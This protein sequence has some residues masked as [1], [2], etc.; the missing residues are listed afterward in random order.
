[1]V[2]GP[3]WRTAAHPVAAR[4]WGEREEPATRIEYTLPGRT[5]S[6]P[7]PTRPH[8]LTASSATELISE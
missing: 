5:S 4:K 1:M 2:G 6:G 3:G 8:L 7:L